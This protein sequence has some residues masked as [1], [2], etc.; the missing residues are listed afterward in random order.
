[1][2]IMKKPLL[3]FYNAVESQMSGRTREG[4]SLHKLFIWLKAKETAPFL[5]LPSLPSQ[6]ILFTLHTPQS[7]RTAGVFDPV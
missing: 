6:S 3:N 4:K 1:M 7:P 5:L 2:N